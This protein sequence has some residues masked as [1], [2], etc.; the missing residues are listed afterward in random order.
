M[1]NIQISAGITIIMYLVLNDDDPRS[2]LCLGI[3]PNNHSRRMSNRSISM[4]MVYYGTCTNLVA[5]DVDV[6]P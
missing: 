5:L 6:H 1:I 2:I 4:D 3:S